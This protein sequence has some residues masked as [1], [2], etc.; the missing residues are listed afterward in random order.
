[1]IDMKRREITA[2]K[3]ATL[4][5]FTA[6][7]LITFLIENLFPPLVIPGAKMG[8]A[9]IFSLAVLIIYGPWEA[10]TVIAVRTVCGAF[11]AGN[12]SMLLYSFSGGV[13]AIGVSAL[14]MYTVYPRI[15]M[16]AVSIAAAVIHNLT[17]SLV[18][19][20]VSQ[21]PQMLAY[22]PYL[23]L[24]GVLSGIIVGAVT[25]LI[26]KKTPITLYERAIGE[27]Q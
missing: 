23:T 13:V 8:L 19:V 5:I 22:M 14:L 7:S 24:L 16:T 12:P 18:F 26:F 11:L 9:N 1:M 6:L 27:I 15:S 4:A 20:L 2:R 21:T 17:Q 3:L 10:L 25:L